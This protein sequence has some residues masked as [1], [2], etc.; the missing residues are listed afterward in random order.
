MKKK[1]AMG[2]RSWIREPINID[3]AC[4]RCLFDP[5]AAVRLLASSDTKNRQRHV[6]LGRR[7]AHE[8]DN[9]TENTSKELINPQ[10]G[11]A[12]ECRHQSLFAKFLIAVIGGFGD[13][14]G[15]QDEQVARLKSDNAALIGG[16]SKH[17]QDCSTLLQKLCSA[18]V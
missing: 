10:I 18:I 13:P 7:S 5:F 6:I 14:I 17:A 8:S 9:S 1:P 11:L 12:G 2:C 15:V 16:I 4:F 3:F